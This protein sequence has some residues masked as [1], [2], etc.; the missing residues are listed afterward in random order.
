MRIFLVVL[1]V[2]FST[3]RMSAKVK[4]YVLPYE[5]IRPVDVTAVRPPCQGDLEC[6]DA[7]AIIFIHGI[8][9]D[10]KTFSSVPLSAN[11]RTAG[12]PRI[13]W[14]FLIPERI[15]GKRVDVYVVRY[16]TDLIAWLEKD[17]STLDEVVYGLFKGLDRRLLG[18][19]YKSI[20]I[21]A[22]SLGGNVATSYLHTVKTELGHDQRARHSFLITLGTPT[23]GA[24]IAAVGL[25]AKKFLG[26]KDP[27]LTSLKTDNTFLRML[28]YWRYS[29]DGKASRF[30]CRP[31]HFYAAL[32]GA[33]T[34]G[35]Q[36]VSKESAEFMKQGRIKV[37]YKTFAGLNHSQL[38]KPP[39]NKEVRDWVDDILSNEIGRVESWDV[40]HGF[41][42][43]L[44]GHRY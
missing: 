38:A 13:D 21:I 20:G 37:E 14:P 42:E 44:C 25:W 18:K 6:K 23:D 16:E 10:D 35:I 4:D 34:R 29:E 17:I 11:P 5:D 41:P 12:S 33:K 24:D 26:M 2:L 1:L 30:G 28:A 7:H 19:K 22:H 39:G 27:L 40:Q 3:D 32:E 36:V 43:K 15:S 8:F 31:V 9:G